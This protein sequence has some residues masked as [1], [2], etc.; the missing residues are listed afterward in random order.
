MTTTRLRRDDL[1][2]ILEDLVTRVLGATHALIVT[3]DSL[4]YAMS[5]SCADLQVDH[6][7]VI[8]GGLLSL[9]GNTGE[10]L[11]IGECQQMILRHSD[12]LVF[13]APLAGGGG[14]ALLTEIDVPLAVIAA[15]MR[16]FWST[17]AA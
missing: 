14:L 8:S 9:A 6:W 15:E 1:Q 5:T 13:L 10:L 12:G 16:L 11:R 17:L 7:S 2:Q 3:P 4:P